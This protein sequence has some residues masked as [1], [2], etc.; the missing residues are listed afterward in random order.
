[1]IVKAIGK[2]VK[3]SAQKARIPAQIVVGMPVEEGLA[4]LKYMPKRAA[5]DVWKVVNSAKANA[6]NNHSM[7]G[8][9]LIIRSVRVDGA[10]KYRRMKAGSRGSAKFFDRRFSNI[11]VEVDDGVSLSVKEDKKKAKSEKTKPVSEE[12]ESKEAPKAKKSSAAAKTSAPKA[13][14]EVKAVKN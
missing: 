8:S 3:G 11:M 6:V 1:M 2:N 14:K 5:R 4:I 13:K 12:K 7:D 9:K 10:M